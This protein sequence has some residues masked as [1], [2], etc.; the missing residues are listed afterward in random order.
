MRIKSL[1][2]SNFRNISE[3][4]L[5]FSDKF[6]IEGRTGAGKTS[7]IE[8]CYILSSGKSFKTTQ[9]KE[10]IKNEA[11]NFFIKCSA[12]DIEG[13]SR[14]ISIGYDT[15]DNRKI[16][17]DG[18]EVRRKSLLEALLPVV[19]SSFDFN[20]I[21]GGPKSRRDFIDKVC[22]VN[23]NSYLDDLGSYLSFLKNKNT[24]LKNGNA[25]VIKYLNLAAIPLI[26]RIRK[27]R[28]ETIEKVNKKIKET[29]LRLF[30]EI[31]AFFCYNPSE[32]IEK[33]LE[34][35]LELELSKGFCLY[36]PH[37]DQ[38]NLNIKS[39]RAKNNISMG[40]TYINSFLIKLSE[41]GIY[42]DLKLHPVFF[43]DDIFVFVDNET[44]KLLFDEIERLDNQVIMTS[45]LE[46]LNKFNNIEKYYL[47][48]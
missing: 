42:E 28:K 39:G 46:N 17:M 37:L 43:I 45:S 21:T 48:R 35:I 5:E 24:A 36:G 11:N 16:L 34:G 30:P 29:S 40:E 44:K 15:E 20:L 13:Y 12:E 27:K 33:K 22:F 26:N 41:I 18:S 25:K 6:L 32:D 47:S 3:L 23:D 9:L 38:I 4:D 2:L 31:T 14:E 10:C 7:I 8:A 1:Y 19:H